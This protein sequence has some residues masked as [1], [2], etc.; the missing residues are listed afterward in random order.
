MPI[1]YPDHYPNGPHEDPLNP[2]E[3]QHV[4]EITD[5][6]D[7]HQTHYCDTYEDACE[8]ADNMEDDGFK[9]VITSPDWKDPK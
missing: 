8:F 5:G 4:V 3:G 2:I 9:A 1:E 6:K 7:W